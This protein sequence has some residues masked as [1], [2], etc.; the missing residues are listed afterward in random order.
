[1]VRLGKVE[2]DC[3][4]PWTNDAPNV[5][6]TWIV[7][8]VSN[9][10]WNSRH[11]MVCWY[12]FQFNEW[13]NTTVSTIQQETATGTYQT[14]CSY[15]FCMHVRKRCTATK[16]RCYM[17]YLYL[18]Q[19]N[20]WHHNTDLQHCPRNVFET[21]QMPTSGKWSNIHERLES[22]Q[23]QYESIHLSYEPNWSSQL[24]AKRVNYKWKDLIKNRAPLNYCRRSQK[25]NI[26]FWKCSI[27]SNFFFW[28][29]KS[30]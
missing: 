7:E 19:N 9:V 5:D 8:I 22:F 15:T 17:M 24:I 13:L 10:I 20:K 4:V 11:A 25:K 30:R 28:M 29:P 23:C 12:C 21:L 1:M 3:I 26:S 18:L 2:V 14:A 27:L 6:Y 16:E